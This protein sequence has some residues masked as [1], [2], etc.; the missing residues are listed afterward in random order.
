MLS[1]FSGVLLTHIDTSNQPSQKGNDGVS[2]GKASLGWLPLSD[3][4]EVR[5]VQAEGIFRGQGQV[6]KWM[7]F[8]EGQQQAQRG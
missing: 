7:S 8:Q 4:Q 3:R 1:L 6:R 5:V 2:V